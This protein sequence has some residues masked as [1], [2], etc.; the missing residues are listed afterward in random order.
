VKTRNEKERIIS[1]SGYAG[2]SIHYRAHKSF[3]GKEQGRGAI[4]S[5]DKKHQESGIAYILNKL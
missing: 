3:S 5:L 1:I 4:N 2:Q